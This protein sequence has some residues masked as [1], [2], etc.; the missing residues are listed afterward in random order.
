MIVP[1]IRQEQF[2]CTSLPIYHSLM[3]P[4]FDCIP[5]ENTEIK[6]GKIKIW[7]EK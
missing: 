5:S 1:E 2:P 7:Q 4:P 6:I 3:T